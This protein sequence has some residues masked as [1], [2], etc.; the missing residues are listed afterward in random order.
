MNWIKW[1][2][3][4]LVAAAVALP[5]IRHIRSSGGSQEGTDAAPGASPIY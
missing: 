3:L 1:T 2:A 4:G 5:L